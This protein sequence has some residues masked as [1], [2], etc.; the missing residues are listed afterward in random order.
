M[1]RSQKLLPVV[2]VAEQREHNAAREFGDSLRQLEQQQKQLDNLV[3]YRANYAEHYLSAT[4]T[5]LSA[6]QMRDYQVFLGR[7]DEAIKQQQQ[8]VL[9]GVQDRDIS[10]SNWQGAAGHSKMINNVVEKRQQSEKQQLDRKEQRE[11]DESAL[12][13]RFNG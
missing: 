8:I 13:K 5:G 3:A 11:L 9:G 7:L 10:Q 1:K 6:V 2:K 12:S 4:K